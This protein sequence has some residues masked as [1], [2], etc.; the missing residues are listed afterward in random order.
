[1]SK[2]FFCALCGTKLEV[3]RKAI[4]QRGIIVNLVE[5]HVCSKT[6]KDVFDVI[7][8]EIERATSSVKTPSI[9]QAKEE[10][11]K[12]RKFNKMFAGFDFV[13]KINKAIEVETPAEPGD[14]R[15]K[16]NQREELVTSSAPTN[17]LS[18]ASANAGTTQPAREDMEE[19]EDG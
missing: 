3:I 8:V 13:Q 14:L 19:P 15:P 18:M 1:M 17:V 10:I 6:T 7:G 2:Q 11:D 16:S 4:P 9:E 12:K 5:P